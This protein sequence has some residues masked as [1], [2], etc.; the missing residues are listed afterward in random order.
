MIRRSRH[1][2][3]T[4]FIIL[5]IV[6][7]L[8]ILFLFYFRGLGGEK[9][10]LDAKSIAP[11]NSL[12]VNCLGSSLEELLRR[13]G[14]NGGYLDTSSLHHDVRVERSDTVP[15]EPQ[16]VPYWSHVKPCSSNPLGCEASEQPPLCEQGSR[17]CPVDSFGRES[18]Q[19]QIEEALPADVQRCLDN[20]ALLNDQYEITVKGEPKASIVFAK[21]DVQATLTLPLLITDKA[22]GKSKKLDTFA[23]TADVNVA[24]VYLLAN[25]IANAERSTSFLERLTLHLISI[26]S[27]VDEPLPP[28]RSVTILGQKHFWSRTQIEQT[29]QEDVLPWVNFIQVP[30]AP[31][32]FAPVWPSTA[33]AATLTEEEQAMY[34]G[35][36]SYLY[37]KLGNETYPDTKVRFFYPYSRPYLSIN[38]G[39]ELLKPRSA[40]MGGLLQK[41]VG[42]FMNDYRFNYDLTYPVIVTVTDTEAFGGEGYDWSF[43]LQANIRRNQPL[44]R[45]AAVSSFL[46]LNDRV[47]FSAPQQRVRNVIAIETINKLTGEPLSD[48]RISYR[49]GDDFFVG[50]TN[51]EGKLVTRFPYCR[52]GGVILYS[53]EGYLGSGQE[54]DNY[55]ENVVKG[56]NLALWPLQEV[57]FSV[58]K[59]TAEQVTSLSETTPDYESIRSK[60]ENLTENDLVIFNIER[61]KEVEYEEDVPMVGFLTFTV[62]NQTFDAV[63]AKRSELEQLKAQGVISEEDYALYL[64]AINDSAG[65]LLAPKQP[66][67]TLRLA[68]GQYSIEAYLIHTKP[69]SIPTE[70]R[71]FCLVDLGI[72]CAKKKEFTLEGT[73][74]NM[75]LSGGILMN[76]SEPLE[77]GQ[78]ILYQHDRYTFYAL[79]SKLPANWQDLEEYKPPEEYLQNKRILMMPTYG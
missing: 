51:T 35:I 33:E 43:A 49:C 28:M 69:L 23:A 74:L 8:G 72:A 56:F 46:L 1:G 32:G 12:V 45:S 6:L 57:T 65:K 5:G 62:E 77:L 73:T 55:E 60:S 17:S 30:N 22:S 9:D 31:A 10:D 38:G 48:V 70:T 7:L 68:P 67:V 15:F 63:A 40:E 37:V 4:L 78:N 27:G 58:R 59:R 64:Q 52:Y 76:A 79:E 20:F 34:A 41:L 29:L 19:G 53:K 44:N 25:S 26:Y 61:V 47:D 71:E 50:E 3:L 2:Q 16:D 75:W 42:L 54:F 39:Q 13:A 11:V 18:V 14:A 36:F 21:K 66:E 24:K